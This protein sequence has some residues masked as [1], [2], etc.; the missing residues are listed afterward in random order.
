M[1][2][3]HDYVYVTSSSSAGAAPRGNNQQIPQTSQQQVRVVTTTNAQVSYIQTGQ[4]IVTTAA[5]RQ[6][7]Y[8]ART[9][10]VQNIRVVEQSRTRIVT[11]QAQRIPGQQQIQ[12]NVT[13]IRRPV[14]PQF[15]AAGGATMNSVRPVLG[16]GQR[17][18]QPQVV[19]NLRQPMIQQQQP[20]QRP[21]NVHTLTMPTMQQIQHQRHQQQQQQ[22][23][24]QQAQ[25]S[26]QAQQIAMQQQK[27]QQ[28]QQQH[29]QIQQHGLAQT[30]YYQHRTG[31]PVGGMDLA[32]PMRE[33][34][35]PPVEIKQ[36]IVDEEEPEA[37]NAEPVPSAEDGEID[38]QIRN[39]VCNYTLPLHIDLK[40]LA[41]NSN[42]VTYDRGRGVMMKQKRSPNCFIKMYSSG[43]VYIVGCRSEVECKKAARRVAR[44]VQKVMGKEESRVC[45]R[46]YKVNNVLA[47]CK[48][49][50]GIKIE[51]LAQKYPSQSQYEPELSV[52]LIWRNTDP[53]ATLR[54]H[55]TGSITVTGASS[56]AAV[57][58]VI[59]QI[60]PIVLEFRCAHRARGT[61]TKRKRKAPSQPRAP[62]KVKEESYGTSGVI[63]NKVYFSD[64]EDIY[65]DDDLEFEE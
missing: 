34:T 17:I 43:K 38:I 57:M 40:K 53:K 45:I 39:V 15:S 27:I 36:E 28:Q 65:D 7:F 31:Y 54:I 41:M 24:L 60:W 23:D 10:P 6:V 20:I 12:G 50:F 8:T 42:N 55:T 9:A 13:Y 33:P 3:D 5:G 14:N 11:G 46:N 44:H 58:T 2:V 62:K 49:P 35:P 59:E 61:G 21:Q 64:E 25:V 47:T 26:A 18:V 48:M 30:G 1:S 63:G 51:E 22:M 52:G 56:E 29:V 37:S 4:K 19:S 32:I 16:N